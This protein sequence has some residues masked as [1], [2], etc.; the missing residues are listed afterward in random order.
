VLCPVLL[1]CDAKVDCR[2]V[3]KF[4]LQDQRR[5]K[6]RPA[7]VLSENIQAIRTTGGRE[8]IP[9]SGHLGTTHFSKT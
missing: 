3:P 6:R 8:S 2:G 4:G 7:S 9:L 1:P 5:R